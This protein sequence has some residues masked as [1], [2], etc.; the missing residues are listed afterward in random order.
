MYSQ[1]LSELKH[2]LSRHWKA[3]SPVL[4]ACSGG[5]D[6]KALLYL[7]LEAQTF[8]DLEIQVAHIDHGWRE[9]SAEE[10]Q[11]LKAEVEGLGLVFHLRTLT[12][13]PMKEEA[14][15]D[16]RYEKLK[17]IADEIGAQSI[18][19]AHQMEDQAETVLK[20][21][22]EG[23]ALSSCGG[24]KE[25]SMN[26]WRPLLKV[27]KK[28]LV[29][30]LEKRGISYFIDSTNLDPKYLRGRLRSSILPQLEEAFGKSIVKNL[31][32]LGERAQKLE[33]HL[34]KASSGL[35]EQKIADLKECDEIVLEFFLKSRSRGLSREE[36]SI[37][38]KKLRSDDPQKSIELALIMQKDYLNL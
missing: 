36:L 33:E 25:V 14:A 23:S 24:M 12:D 10:A 35:L 3:G 37:L 22:F 20:R 11:K 26:L 15:R 27:L 30:W 21:I 31:C 19:L 1:A 13:L 2:F 29:Q 7:L 28:E 6:S 38:A 8:F 5:P 18:L 4:L 17:Q 9:E 32:L 34:T 16:G